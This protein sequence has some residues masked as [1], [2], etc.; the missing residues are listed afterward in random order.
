[1]Y[2][3]VKMILF[4]EHFQSTADLLHGIVSRLHNAGTQKQS[5]NI[6][7][8]VELHRKGAD[9]LWCKGGPGNVIA[10][11]VQAIFAVMNTFVG[12]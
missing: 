3:A 6:V 11:P 7:A 5:F 8:P 12:K 2:V 1:M 4:P 10:A 9:L